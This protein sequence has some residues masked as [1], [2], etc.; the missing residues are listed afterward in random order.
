MSFTGL[1]HPTYKMPLLTV[2]PQNATNRFLGQVI[3]RDTDHAL[4][5]KILK[6][7]LQ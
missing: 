4:L 6:E 5:I 3:S 2:D 7:T 1:P